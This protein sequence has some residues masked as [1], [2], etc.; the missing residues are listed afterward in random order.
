M[1]N[2][3][4]QIQGLSKTYSGIKV[5]KEINFNVK[6][7]EVHALVGENGAGKTTL[8][9]IIAGVEKPDPGGK[10][11]FDKEQIKD[12][13]P[14][15]SIGMGI[16]VIYQDI[17]LFPNMSVAENICIGKSEDKLINWKEI[18]RVAKEGLNKIGC[19]NIDVNEKFGNISIGKQQIVALAR[20]L[21]QKSR[22]IIM[23][24]PTAALSASE[25]ERLY[26]IIENLKKNNISVIYISHKLDE[27]FSVSDRISVLRDG[28][29]IETRTAKEFDNESLI[30]MMVGRKLRFLP[31]RNE[32]E[33]GE[34]IFE[35]KKLTKEPLFRDISFSLYKHEI[36]GI[37][38]LVGARRSEMAQTLFGLLKP[39]K[40]TIM[41][42]DKEIFIKSTSYAIN[43]GICYLPEDRREKGLFLERDMV[44]NITATNLDNILSKFKFINEKKEISLTKKYIDKI[45]IK[46]KN[47]RIK[48]KFMSGGNQQKVLISRW[49][50]ANPKLLIVD[51]PT[52]GVDIGAKAEIHRILRGLAKSG[53]GVI[54]ISSDLSEALAISDRIL[55]MRNGEIVD[56]VR[57]DVAT[58]E[59]VIKKGIIG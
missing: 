52:K 19:A 22:I 33:I 12:I 8:I 56:E 4:L 27:I 43:K 32:Q 31:M 11:I 50:S 39:D 21:T 2:N 16:S 45:N 13:T 29:K 58:Q 10:I 3:I 7:G 17:S 26:K 51:E 15:K 42:E 47:P 30:T 38:G 9:K 55:I 59:D 28:E 6:E 14:V 35:V 23:D 53:V 40:G 57:A 5:L 46:P 20:A 1:D 34:K 41:M 18:N 44:K 24:E 25:V 37:T 48:V 36:L 54:L 49:L